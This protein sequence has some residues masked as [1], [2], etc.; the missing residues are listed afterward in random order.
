MFPLWALDVFVSM[1]V[2]MSL[3]KRVLFCL[4]ECVSCVYL[5]LCLCMCAQSVCMWVFVNEGTEPTG[6]IKVMSGVTCVCVCV[7]IGGG[8]CVGMQYAN[9][10]LV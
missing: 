9:A 1:L 5:F 10:Y 2:Y 6:N 8:G 3:Q 7:C 4:S